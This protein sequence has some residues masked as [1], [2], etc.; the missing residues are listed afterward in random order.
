MTE[1]LKGIRVIESAMLFNG[2][3]LGSLLGDMGADVIKVESPGG[4]YL[5]DMLGQVAPHYSPAHLEVNKNKRSMTLDLRVDAGRA[6]FWRLLDTADVFV[7]G[8]A[9]S[10]MARLGVGY[11]QQQARKPDI[12]YC[13]YTGYGSAGPYGTI[14][15]HG[16]M[17][18]AL[19]GAMPT[20]MGDDGFM[21]SFVPDTSMGTMRDGGGGPS[22][23]AVYAAFAVAAALVQRS[24]TG[25]G[26]YIDAAG[27]DAVAVN[28][29][30][31]LTYALNDKRIT[32]RSSLPGIRATG[33]DEPRY[34][35]YAT[36]DGK[37]LL[38]CCI[39][40]RFWRNF[41]R[42][43]GREDL[44]TPDQETGPVE[45]GQNDELRRE[46][47]R[48]IVQRDLA[49]WVRMAAEHRIPMG[50]AYVSA[51]ELRDDPHLRERELFVD[52]EHPAVGPYTNIGLPTIVRGQP[53][54]L[55]RHAPAL[56]EHTDE[57]LGELGY[58]P[59]ERASL[60]RQGVVS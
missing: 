50:P 53:Y 46:L 6:V 34:Q 59:E 18:D 60:A 12:V 54:R 21:H 41:C 40:P 15:T 36:R 1:L 55:H 48:I 20:R 45:F 27:S 43:A 56:G 33:N 51:G 25:Q 10:A 29:W 24:R 9:G 49:D 23:G 14:P 11:E 58:P 28:A 32:D 38:F 39:E 4:D 2:D 19:V 31:H 35:Y 3:R 52:T 26:V 44:L 17:M 42:A 37:V 57:V 7:D 47:Q 13:Q 16:Q 5:R 8:N 22:T 30:I